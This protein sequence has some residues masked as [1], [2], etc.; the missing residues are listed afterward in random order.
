MSDALLDDIIHYG[1]NADR[2]AFT[3]DPPSV[4]GAAV[5]LLYLWR[6]TDTGNLYVYDTTWHLIAGSGAFSIGALLTADPGS[7]ADDT[8]W[9]VRTGTTPTMTVALK[10]RIAGVTYTITSITL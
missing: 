1:T 4:G 8:W 3:P 6:E 7:P 5:K 10:A 2:L 9:V